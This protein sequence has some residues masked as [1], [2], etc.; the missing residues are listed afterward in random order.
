M[1]AFFSGTYEKEIEG[2]SEQEQ[3]DKEEEDKEE[4]ERMT[5]EG[6]SASEYD[7]EE[8]DPDFVEMDSDEEMERLI[9]NPRDERVKRPPRRMSV[10]STSNW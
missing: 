9:M 5:I 3:E 2:V 1:D 7:T 10:I 4:E 6:D 8:D